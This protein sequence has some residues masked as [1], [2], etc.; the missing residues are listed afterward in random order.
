V[1]Q[2]ERDRLFEIYPSLNF[3]LGPDQIHRLKK[4]TQKWR[5]DSEQGTGGVVIA[6]ELI[7]DPDEY[8]WK[9]LNDIPLVTGHRSQVT[10]FVTIMKGCNNHCSFCIV[11]KVRGSEISRPADD[12][13]NEIKRL[14]AIGIKEVTLLGQNVNSYKSLQPPFSKR[15]GGGI[16]PFV[17]LLQ[18]ISTETGIQRIRYTSPHPKD[19]GDDLIEEHAANPKLCS[20]MHLPLQAGSDRVLRLMKRSYNKKQF[21]IKAARLR[22]R[23]PRIDITTDVIVGFPGE[24]ESEFKDTLDVVRE[25]AFDGMF[26]FKY[27]PRPGTKAADLKDD[28]PQEEKES[29]LARLL[30]LN[31]S[32]WKERTERLIGTVQEVLVE[33]VSKK[34]FFPN[35]ECQLTGRSFAN[36]IVNF[37]GN[38][39]LVGHI[40]TV[41][42]ISAGM[43]S[44]K[45]KIV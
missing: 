1:A 39:N 12:I 27:S 25:V 24:T 13:I 37:A 45:G 43:N 38:L 16:T 41:E 34:Q 33:G 3:V 26:A 5:V 42:I 30:D 22:E 32:I 11:P 9:Y 15:G 21:I 10:A 18:N 17:N 19:L 6:A 36:K 14:T 23:V 29:R 7:D 31:A 44:L 40:V 35:G 4:F 20:H 2:Q 8:N 28:V